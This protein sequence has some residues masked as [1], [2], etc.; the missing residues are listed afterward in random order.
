MRSSRPI[1]RSDHALR[2]RTG[3]QFAFSKKFIAVLVAI[4]PIG[5]AVTT[6]ANINFLRNILGI[7]LPPYV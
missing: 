4:G 3:A 7:K 1:K 2:F 5:L 6:S